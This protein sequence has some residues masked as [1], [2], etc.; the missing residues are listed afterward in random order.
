MFLFGDFNIHHKDCLTLSVGTERSGEL[1]YNFSISDDFNQIVNCLT[2][3][4]DCDSHSPALLD[5]FLSSDAS[6]CSTMAFSPLGNSDHVVILV[7]IDLPSNSQWDGPFHCITYHYS[8]ANWNSLHD[9]LRDVRWEDIFKLGASVASS[10]FVSGF[11]LKL[12]YISLI[13]NIGSSITHL[14][15]FQLLVLL[16]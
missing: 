13:E 5:F 11:R 12:M 2:R 8:C 4:L 9:H 1:C 6:I 10:E 14:H 7:Y 16:P 3:I 15:G